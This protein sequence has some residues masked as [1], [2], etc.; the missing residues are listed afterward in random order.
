[1]H[2]AMRKIKVRVVHHE[3]NR[4]EKNIIYPAA[5]ADICV[6]GGMRYNFRVGK[7]NIGNKRKDHDREKG[8]KDLTEVI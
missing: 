5:V 6:P 4:V 2:E 3:Q 7:K 8:K 1:M